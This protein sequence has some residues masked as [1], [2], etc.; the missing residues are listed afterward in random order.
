MKLS[1]YLEMKKVRPY[2]WAQ[3]HGFSQGAI[4]AWIRG[5][6]KPTLPTALK[7]QLLTGGDVRPDDWLN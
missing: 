1:E 4:Y 6:A 2:K 7:S 3:V 5:E